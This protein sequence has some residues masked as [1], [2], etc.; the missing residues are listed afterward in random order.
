ML[1][2]DRCVKREPDLLL[3]NEQRPELMG[4]SGGLM[5]LSVLSVAH[6]FDSLY[7]A[8]L[9]VCGLLCRVCRFCY[10]KSRAAEDR[11]GIWGWAVLG[12]STD[13]LRTVLE[14]Y[15]KSIVSPPDTDPSRSNI[16]V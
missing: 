4:I 5:N 13:E 7:Q 10:L 6:D 1:T 15:Q 8:C 16:I 14:Q 2:L 9:E 3:K 11:A 12:I